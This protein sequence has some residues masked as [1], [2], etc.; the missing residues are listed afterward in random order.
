[1][2]L[3]FKRSLTVFRLQNLQATGLWNG[4][5]LYRVK[6]GHLSAFPGATLN[7]APD[8]S[9]PLCVL[10][11]AVLSWELYM[12]MWVITQSALK[13]Q[14]DVSRLNFT[15]FL[16]WYWGLDSGPCAFRQALYYLSHTTWSTLLALFLL[17]I[18]HIESHSVPLPPSY[19]CFLNSW[20]DRCTPA[21]SAFNWLRWDLTNFLPWAGLELALSL[22]SSWA[23]R[24]EP[25]CLA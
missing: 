15:L 9:V 10:C 20:D 8:H 11:C 16:W 25:P 3:P 1:V 13:L 12:I 18:I 6:G 7:L 22:P 19:L 17:G 23:Y 2:E 4:S 14:V 24:R 21:C 5:V